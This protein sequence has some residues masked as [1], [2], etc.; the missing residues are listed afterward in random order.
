MNKYEVTIIK[1]VH[2][3][4]GLARINR[5][6]VFVPNV[7]ENEIVEA[8]GKELVD[9]SKIK[10]IYLPIMPDVLSAKFPKDSSIPV[11]SVCLS[12]S[13]Q[14]VYHANFALNEYF[15]NKIWYF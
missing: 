10:K 15:R 11:A 3:G 5:K 8:I 14:M 7:L 4:Y 6:V 2:Q 9:L 1:M 13:C 12:D